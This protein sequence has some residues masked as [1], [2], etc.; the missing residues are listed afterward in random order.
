MKIAGGSNDAML[1]GYL[2]LASNAAANP[3]LAKQVA[4]LYFSKEM[5]NPYHTAWAVQKG[6]ALLEVV[7]MFQLRLDQVI[8]V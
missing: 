4:K 2:M 7:N 8:L 1:T 6:S 5:I 3:T